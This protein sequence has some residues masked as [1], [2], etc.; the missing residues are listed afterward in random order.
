MFSLVYYGKWINYD[1][2]AVEVYYACEEFPISDL[3]NTNVNGKKL[4]LS[5]IGI[6]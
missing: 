4:Y 1:Q 5:N 2:F 3:L 6:H